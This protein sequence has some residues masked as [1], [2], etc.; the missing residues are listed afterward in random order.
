MDINVRRKY[1]PGSPHQLLCLP[2]RRLTHHHAGG[3]GDIRPFAV[4]HSG[5]RGC[6]RGDRA[7]DGQDASSHS[8]IS[9]RAQRSS[10]GHPGVPGKTCPEGACESGRLPAPLL[11]PPSPCVSPRSGE[12]SS[13]FPGAQE[14]WFMAAAGSARQEALNYRAL[15]D[16]RA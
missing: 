14:T 2:R 1:T 3:R 4:G 16:T 10:A 15:R 5:A 6:D 13:V 12:M 9:P 7:C 8:L 11:H